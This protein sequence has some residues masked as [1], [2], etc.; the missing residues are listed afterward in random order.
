MVR[1]R[2]R[3]L[4]G[5]RVVLAARGQHAEIAI[6]SLISLEAA[7]WE[8]R[9]KGVF[10]CCTIYLCTIHTFCTLYINTLQIWITLQI[11]LSNMN[12]W[13]WLMKKNP[14]K[15]RNAAYTP[16]VD[17]YHTVITAA[18]LGQ[19]L[20]YFIFLLIVFQKAV[21]NRK[22]INQSIDIKDTKHIFTTSKQRKKII[23]C[24]KTIISA[25]DNCTLDLNWSNSQLQIK[26][27]FYKRANEI[28]EICCRKCIYGTVELEHCYFL[29]VFLSEE[30]IPL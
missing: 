25:V 27:K 5:C 17:L 15:H 11:C 26:R 9:G 23:A 6:L 7:F 12:Y 13:D 4:D 21:K 24:T 30:R 3:V 20:K 18:R 2:V 22:K 16:T 1:G 28:L 29:L 14:E 8:D 19:P 10:N